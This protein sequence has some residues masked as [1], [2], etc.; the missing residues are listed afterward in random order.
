MTGISEDDRARLEELVSAI[1][2]K[3][4]LE[5]FS[6][7][8]A[9][10]AP[11]VKSLAFRMGAHDLADEIAQEA[12]FTIWR[13]AATHTAAKATV[14][15]WVYTVARGAIL[16]RLSRQNRA[17]PTK[18]HAVPEV[19]EDACVGRH[20]DADRRATRLRAAIDELPPE[21]AEV[22]RIAYFEG[23]SYDRIAEQL[24]LPVSTVTLR[25]R[26]AAAHLKAALS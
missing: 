24:D 13:D 25:I 21:Q 5:A 4:D 2:S 15:T 6:I 23:K 11:K 1:A 19:V 16:T 7:L 3:C 14:S 10:F 12:L 26:Q 22:L 8:Y 17:G 9:H 20:V 18:H